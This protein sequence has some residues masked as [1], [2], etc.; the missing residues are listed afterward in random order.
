MTFAILSST[1]FVSGCLSHSFFEH[2]HW[3][4]VRT[5]ESTSP[6][7]ERSK[8]APAVEMTWS[9]SS[10]ERNSSKYRTHGSRCSTDGLYCG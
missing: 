3:N 9:T 4:D 6:A 8:R 1:I 2:Q 5:G 7:S 10:C